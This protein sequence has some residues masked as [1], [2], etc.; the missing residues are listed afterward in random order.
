MIFIFPSLFN[1][2]SKGDENAWT[3]HFA[4]VAVKVM[5]GGGRGKTCLMLRNT[6]WEMFFLHGLQTVLKQFSC[7]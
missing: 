7:L 2:D 3:K 4:R 1:A 6:C 5:C